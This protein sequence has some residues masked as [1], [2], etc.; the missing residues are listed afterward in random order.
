MDV[1][2]IF[3]DTPVVDLKYNPL[4]APLFCACSNDDFAE[5][6]FPDWSYWSGQVCEACKLQVPIC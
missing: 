4:A 2:L 5:I 6:P 1:L 3:A